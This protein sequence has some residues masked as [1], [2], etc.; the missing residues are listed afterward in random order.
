MPLAILWKCTNS[1]DFSLLAFCRSGSNF[2]NFFMFFISVDEGR[3]DK[4]AIIGPPAKR[5]FN[6]V[7]LTGRVW[8]NIDIEY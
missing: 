2:D 5:H 6:G 8:P 7:L 1:P 4:L 3:K